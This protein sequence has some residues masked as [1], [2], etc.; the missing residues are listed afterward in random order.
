MKRYSTTIYRNPTYRS[1]KYLAEMKLLTDNGL[2]E[3]V[4]V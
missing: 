3:E 2:M 4:E 1:G